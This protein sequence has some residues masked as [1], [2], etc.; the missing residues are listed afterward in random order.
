MAQRQVQPNEARKQSALRERICFLGTLDNETYAIQGSTGEKVYH[1]KVAPNPTCTCPDYTYRRN[2]CKHIY[3]MLLRM[4]RVPDSLIDDTVFLD[5]Y[6]ATWKSDFASRRLAQQLQDEEEE[7]VIIASSDDETVESSDDEDDTL[8][9]EDEEDSVEI[10]EPVRVCHQHRVRRRALG[11]NCPI[12]LEGLRENTAHA[13]TFCATQCGNNVHLSC[14]QR[15]A[16]HAGEWRCPL[17]VQPGGATSNPS[18]GE[19]TRLSKLSINLFTYN[20]TLPA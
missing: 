17:C 4:L 19:R 14:M 6:I 13:L 8:S 5:S 9:D 7:D 1:V 16:Q 12:C 3:F 15:Y 11:G 20:N 18:S 10:I 2:R